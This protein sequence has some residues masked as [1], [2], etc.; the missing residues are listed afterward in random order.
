[1]P[2][3]N[4]KV[5]FYF[6]SGRLTV[7]KINR[8]TITTDQAYVHQKAYANVKDLHQFEISCDNRRKH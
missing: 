1:M 7:T 2:L 5:C 8:Y 6:I 3:L 4:N